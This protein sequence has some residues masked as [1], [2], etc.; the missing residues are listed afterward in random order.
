MKTL[1]LG[2]HIVRLHMLH[3]IVHDEQGP[4]GEYLPTLFLYDAVCTYLLLETSMVVVSVNVVVIC[5]LAESLR[6]P[7]SISISGYDLPVP[8]GGNQQFKEQ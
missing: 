3:C 1:S 8:N 7:G 5:S 6:C 4:S 2:S